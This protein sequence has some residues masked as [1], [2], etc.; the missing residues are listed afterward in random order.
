M[1]GPES[2]GEGLA[3]WLRAARE[4]ALREAAAI[5]GKHKHHWE[6]AQRHILALIP[7]DGEKP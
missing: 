5:V 7:K 4:D 1:S 6:D 2:I 3:L